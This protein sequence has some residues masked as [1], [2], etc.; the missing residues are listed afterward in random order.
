[1]PAAGRSPPSRMSM[2]RAA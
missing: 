1:L 2:I